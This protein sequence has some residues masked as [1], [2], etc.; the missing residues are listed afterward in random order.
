MKLP[1]FLSDCHSCL[2]VISDP[3]AF[4]DSSSWVVGL[5]TRS[6]LTQSQKALPFQGLLVHYWGGTWEAL[7]KNMNFWRRGENEFA[8]IQ[9]DY[10][11]LFC[12]TG[13]KQW[14]WRGRGLRDDIP[15]RKYGHERKCSWIHGKTHH[16]PS[17]LL[18]GWAPFISEEG[19]F[20]EKMSGEENF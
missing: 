10:V 19:T 12:C 17:V 3:L 4:S 7:N 6:T 18:M 16:C 11:F 13:R 14:G 5:T 1:V 9:S 15:G 2:H 8:L 20:S